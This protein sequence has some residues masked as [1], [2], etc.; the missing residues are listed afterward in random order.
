[1]VVGPTHAR[2]RTLGLLMTDVPDLVQ[3][4]IVALIGNSEHSS[5]L[6]VISMAQVIPNL[7]VCRKVFLKHQVNWNTVMV[8]QYRICPVVTFGLLTIL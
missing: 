3:V 4:A 2:G 7:G 6:T 5:L 1:M 8:V